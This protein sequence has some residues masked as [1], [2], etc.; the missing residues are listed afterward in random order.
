MNL[1]TAPHATFLDLPDDVLFR[2][3]SFLPLKTVLKMEH[4]CQRLHQAI[5][6]YLS[7]LKT[8]HLYQQHVKYDVF[9]HKDQNVSVIS[10]TSLAKLLGQC[11]QATSIAYLGSNQTCHQ[12]LLHVIRQFETIT[13]L[14]FVDSKELL[15]EVRMQGLHITPREVCISPVMSNLL[16]SHSVT[17]NRLPETIAILYM[18]D[19]S[20]DYQSLLYFSKCADM[21]F[22]KCCFEVDTVS[23]L[24]SLYFP[25]VS[26]FKYIDQPG[27][28][29]SSRVGAVLVKKATV[30]E[31]L[32]SL[33][34]G[35]TEFSAIFRRLE[36]YLSGRAR[37][38]L[39][40]LLQCFFTAVKVCLHYC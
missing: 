15:D 19:V 6:G 22:I 26:R 5:S 27:R 2:I 8:I 37:S 10:A 30:S 13:V 20:L 38:S 25:N 9:R 34:L 3:F 39:H 35:L 40:W 1:A 11:K 36:S 14:E 7:T 18:E 24:E 21:S 29:A 31:K 28:S 32:K 33:Y 17:L 12:E 16:S 23:E 4:L